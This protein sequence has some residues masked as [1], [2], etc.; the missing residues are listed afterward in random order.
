MLRGLLVSVHAPRAVWAF[1]ISG[2]GSQVAGQ[3]RVEPDG[4]DGC[5]VPVDDQVSAFLAGAVLKTY[6]DKFHKINNQTII[7]GSP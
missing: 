7:L 5:R 4:A 1:H 3:N 6:D 2:H